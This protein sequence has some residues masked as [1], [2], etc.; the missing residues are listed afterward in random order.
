MAFRRASAFAAADMVKMRNAT[1]LSWPRGVSPLTGHCQH[2]LVF[3]LNKLG[4]KLK[5][6]AKFIFW[7]LFCINFKFFFVWQ[8]HTEKTIRFDQIKLK[9]CINVA[10]P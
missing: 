8:E 1:A 9:L 4:E 5:Y 6:F 3:A 2:Y 10:K 7:N